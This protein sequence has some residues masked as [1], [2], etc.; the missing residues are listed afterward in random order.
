[1]VLVGLLVP[2]GSFL[3][4]CSVRTAFRRGDV[5]VAQQR[6]PVSVGSF[7]SNV[8]IALSVAVFAFAVAGF[9]KFKNY[10]LRDRF[11]YTNNPDD[12]EEDEYWKYIYGDVFRFSFVASQLKATSPLGFAVLLLWRRKRTS[13]DSS[14]VDGDASDGSLDNGV[15]CRKRGVQF[16]Q[17]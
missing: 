16:H 2:L 14:V 4:S 3:A 7:Y 1:M 13:V 15:S 9:R 11:R 6:D 17:R 10:Y 8:T 12:F 5:G